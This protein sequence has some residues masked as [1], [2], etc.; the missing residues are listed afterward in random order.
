MRL[1]CLGML[2]DMWRARAITLEEIRAALGT[3]ATLEIAGG[4]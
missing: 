4:S 1:T 3:V 2:N